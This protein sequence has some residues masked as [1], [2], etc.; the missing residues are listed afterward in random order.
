MASL[1]VATKIIYSVATYEGVAVDKHLV[2]SY[3]NLPLIIVANSQ[4][5]VPANTKILAPY[6]SVANSNLSHLNEFCGDMTAP[7]KSIY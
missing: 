4:L 6:S 7:N 2:A 3:V 1:F 5:F